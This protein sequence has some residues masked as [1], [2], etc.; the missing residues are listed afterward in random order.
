MS[1]A[2]VR[3]KLFFLKIISA[4]PVAVLISEKKILF[5]S[6]PETFLKP[7]QSYLQDSIV[8]MCCKCYHTFV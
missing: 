6:L 3:A 7:D 5:K 2:G 4:N 8:Y 1:A